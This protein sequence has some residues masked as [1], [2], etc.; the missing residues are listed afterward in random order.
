MLQY[1]DIRSLCAVEKRIRTSAVQFEAVSELWR[2]GKYRLTQIRL[3]WS[4]CKL[5]PIIIVT[6]TTLHVQFM[7]VCVCVCVYQDSFC[8][9]GFI[10]VGSIKNSLTCMKA[11]NQLIAWFFLVVRGI[12]IQLERFLDIPA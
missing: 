10:L 6:R 8:A 11:F 1:S 3:G 4:D 2:L 12:S 5:E 9:E 7:C